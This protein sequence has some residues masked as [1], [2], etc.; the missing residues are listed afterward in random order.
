M[1]LLPCAPHAPA[2]APVRDLSRSVSGRAAGS[3]EGDAG[4]GDVAPARVGQAGGSE[5]DDVSDGWDRDAADGATGRSFEIRT[6]ADFLKV[7]ADRR[8]VCLREFHVWLAIPEAVM[9]AVRATAEAMGQPAPELRPK[10]DVF[11]W[12]DDGKATASVEIRPLPAQQSGL[13]GW[14]R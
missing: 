5:G 12:H 14:L 8:R 4:P 1:P 9:G 11:V 10:L 6:V 3:R 7:P 2:G 13:W